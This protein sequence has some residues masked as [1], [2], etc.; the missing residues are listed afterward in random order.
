MAKFASSGSD[1]DTVNEQALLKTFIVPELYAE[2]NQF[3]RQTNIKTLD[4]MQIL[5]GSRPNASQQFIDVGCGTG[6]FTR[7]ELLP[8]C[9]PCRRIV[10]TDV[11]REMV[12]YARENFGHPQIAYEVHDIE[13]DV[14]ELVRKYGKFDR[15]YSFFTLHWT[16]DLAGALRNVADLMTDDGEC[17]LVFPARI[18]LYRVWRKIVAVDRWKQ[19]KAV[20]ERLI[21]PSQD[22]GD[23]SGLT[24]YMLGVLEGSNLK[25]RTCQ[26]LSEDLSHMHVDKYVQV[27]LSL[28]PIL[29]LLPEGSKTVFKSDV[30]EIIRKMWT[31]K[32]TGGPQYLSDIFVVHA[33]KL[34]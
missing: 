31:E 14:S 29:P 17:L 13:S 16:V 27:E 10:A 20:I 3:P 32:P 12:E 18:T 22:I 9:Q 5:F 21:P 15:V 4:S 26:V 2:S 11:S 1:A 23:R 28:D 8:R 7:Q 25:P 30:A 24:S 6:D 33:Q 19:Y 34:F